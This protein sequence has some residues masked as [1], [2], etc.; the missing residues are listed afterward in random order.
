MH[1]SISSRKLQA[2]GALRDEN[3]QPLLSVLLDMDDVVKIAE[4]LPADLGTSPD[5]AS[6]IGMTVT[7]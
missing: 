1:I 2:S 7:D 3:E 5:P 6:P 4:T